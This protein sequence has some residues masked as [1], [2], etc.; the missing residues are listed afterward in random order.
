MVSSFY[1]RGERVI[2]TNI[3][4]R[5]NNSNIAILMH[6]FYSEMAFIVISFIT[7]FPQRPNSNRE[8]VVVTDHAKITVCSNSTTQ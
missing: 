7:S 1:G 4:K 2:A 8:R 6:S 5:N 3:Y